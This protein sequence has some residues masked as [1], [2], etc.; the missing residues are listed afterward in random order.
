MA[1]DPNALL[2]MGHCG[3]A[4]GV[5]GEVKVYPVT[6]DP[7]R[8]EDLA[9]VFVGETA[10]TVREH[11]VERVRLQPVKGG[12][13][14]ILKL[15]GVSDRTAAEGLRSQGV[16]AHPDDLPALEEGE[17]FLH[18]LIGLSVVGVDEA[19]EPAGSA[20]GT[21]ADVLTG[22]AQTLFVVRRAGQPDVLVPDVPDI[23]L[24][25][26]VPAGRILIRPPEGLFE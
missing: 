6:D 19:G 25:V 9:R 10:G 24:D 22:G 3:K 17:V 12:A 8:F 18:D 15:E 21:I 1:S 16:Y 20:L 14:V 4:H 26:D 13:L 23:V 11:R 5:V 2:L 7:T